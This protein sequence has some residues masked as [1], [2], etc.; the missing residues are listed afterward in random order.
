[1][2]SVMQAYFSTS[3]DGEFSGNDITALEFMYPVV[4][5]ARSCD[6]A[7]EWKSGIAYNVGNLV[8]YFGNLYQRVRGGW[9]SLGPCN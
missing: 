4:S 3:E 7:N 2:T 8:T 5:T 6:G 1:M 9:N